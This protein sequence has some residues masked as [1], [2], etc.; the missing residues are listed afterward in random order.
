MAITWTPTDVPTIAAEDLAAPMRELVAKECGL[1][2]LR[3]LTPEDARIVESCLRQRLGRDPS[4]EL[5]VL[6]RFRALVE[7]FAYEPLLDLFL[8]HGFEMIG[9]AIEI[10]ASTSVGV[11]IRNTS[12]ALFPH[13]SRGVTAA[14]TTSRENCS[15]RLEP[16]ASC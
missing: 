13:G 12:T 7:V 6:M 15:M 2:F 10:A 16:G 1:I 14:F 9:P 11:S 5:A 8:D 4:L 3:G